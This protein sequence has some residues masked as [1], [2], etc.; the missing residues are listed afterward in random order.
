MSVRGF[1]LLPFA[2]LYGLVTWIRNLLFDI[3]VFRQKKHA[4]PI[5]SVGN[6]SMGGTG[7]TPMVEHLIRMLGADNKVATLSRGYGRKSKGFV[8]ADKKASVKTIGDESMQYAQKFPDI[9]VAVCENRNKGVVN[10]LKHTPDLKVVLLDDAFQHRSIKPGLSII[11]TDFYHLYTNDYIFPTGTLREFRSGAKRADIVIVTKTPVV[12]SPI[13]RRRIEGELALRRNQLLLFS[14]ITYD[15]FTPYFENY[16]QKA[17]K[18]YS[19]IVMFTGIAN[20]Y[21]LQ[22]YLKKFCTELT[23]ISFPDHHDFTQKDIDHVLQTYNEVFSKNKMLVSTEKD[24]M[25]LTDCK[26]TYLFEGIPFY[27]VP[28]RITFHNGD[29]KALN[30]TISDFLSK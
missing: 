18:H 5:I 11:L 10:L 8:F 28:I 6:L 21:P 12:L 25:R 14:K 20:N 1:F 29:G 22:D 4:V 15:T 26:K 19:H 16:K 7:K 3:G 24:I 13:T 27:F 9:A 23:V 30:N 2:L 17:K